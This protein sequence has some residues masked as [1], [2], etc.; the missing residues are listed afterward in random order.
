M[1][2]FI[3]ERWKEMC[4]RRKRKRILKYIK[5]A[6]TVYISGEEIFMCTCFMRVLGCKHYEIQQIIPEFKREL[7]NAEPW[8]WDSGI[9]WLIENRKSRIKAFDKL[10]EI[11][12][13]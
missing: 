13:E 6:K 2:R 1:F 9:W 4:R 12:S 5:K 8:S 7:L 3:K 11:Y 10:I